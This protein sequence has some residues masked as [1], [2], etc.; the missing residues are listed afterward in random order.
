MN[1]IPEHLGLVCCYERVWLTFGTFVLQCQR[2][3][4][5]QQNVELEYF[6]SPFRY[7]F[8]RQKLLKQNS[9]NFT[10][11]KKEV[12]MGYARTDWELCQFKVVWNWWWVLTISLNCLKIS[13]LLVCIH[14]Q[15]FTNCFGIYYYIIWKYNNKISHGQVLNLSKI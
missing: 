14:Q 8:H 3:L 10:K 7:K 12:I 5:I 4:V 1:G 9:N 6:S 11:P 15:L 2:T 13:L